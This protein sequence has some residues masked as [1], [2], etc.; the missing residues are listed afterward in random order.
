MSREIITSRN[1]FSKRKHL[2]AGAFSYEKMDNK[3]IEYVRQC[4]P[5]DIHRFYTWSKWERVRQQVLNMDKYECQD[6]K[7]RGIYTKATT[8]HHQQYVK[9]HPE[10][11]LEIWYTF[12]GK[13]YRNLVSLCHD[14][15]EAR[16]G[17]RQKTSKQLL[18][19]E[20]W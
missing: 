8:V 5:K 1:I 18:T 17:H 15:H 14:C 3:D 4:I 16:H 19:E 10:L 7:A 20:R 11:A 12:K 9:K 2:A 6:C 13:E